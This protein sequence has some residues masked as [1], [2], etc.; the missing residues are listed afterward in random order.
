MIFNVA[1]LSFK[2]SDAFPRILEL[3]LLILI[4]R[5]VSDCDCSL[6]LYLQEL[7]LR[8]FVHISFIFFKLVYRVTLEF[9]LR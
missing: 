4:V 1:E 6:L 8:I 5:L 3:H 2:Q 7:S 9:Y